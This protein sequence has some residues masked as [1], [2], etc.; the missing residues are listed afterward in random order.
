MLDLEW[1]QIDWANRLLHYTSKGKSKVHPL[2]DRVL[3][4]LQAIGPRPTGP[5]LRGADGHYAPA[6]LGKGG[7]SNRA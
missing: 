3:E 5:S 1:T 2:S 6:L 4:L 7:P